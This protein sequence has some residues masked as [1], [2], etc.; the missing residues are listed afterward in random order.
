MNKSSIEQILQKMERTLPVVESPDKFRILSANSINS[1]HEYDLNHSWEDVKGN[2]TSQ[3]YTPIKRVEAKHE[4]KCKSELIQPNLMLNEFINNCHKIQEEIKMTSLNN[5]HNSEKITFLT[6]QLKER[7]DKIE[8]LAHHIAKLIHENSLLKEKLAVS[9]HSIQVHKNDTSNS[10]IQN[11]FESIPEQV[12]P[13]LSHKPLDTSIPLNNS[14][15]QLSNGVNMDKL[16]DKIESMA[17]ETQN[18]SNELKLSRASNTLLA[19]K[20]MQ[21]K[22]EFNNMINTGSNA[23]EKS[24]TSI[25]P[26]YKNEVSKINTPILT[27]NMHIIP[28]DTNFIHSDFNLNSHEQSTKDDHLNVNNQILIGQQRKIHYMEQKCTKTVTLCKNL[29][30]KL[31]NI[32]SIARSTAKNIL[33]TKSQIWLVLASQPTNNEIMHQI[34]H[35]YTTMANCLLSIQSICNQ[36]N[37]CQAVLSNIQTPGRNTMNNTFSS[38]SSI[39]PS[40]IKKHVNNSTIH[41]NT[42][43]TL[44][45]KLR[46]FKS[47]T[48]P[49]FT[50]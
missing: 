20:L 46:Q 36:S 6:D 2:L 1:S 45:G 26:E 50:P 7:D 35:D 43:T 3:K 10:L 41:N 29:E 39:S 49:S 16:N 24:R 42:G 12:N 34:E 47:V 19:E 28:G 13:N 22:N 31:I 18:L 40:T 23:K 27:S 21:Y 33:T 8:Q 17:V 4:T 37:I 11:H 48:A 38:I 32:L 44:N 9:L 25:L 14:E 30:S 15:N 5:C